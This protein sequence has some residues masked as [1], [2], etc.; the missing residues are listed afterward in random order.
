M[1]QANIK[2]WPQNYQK[3][4]GCV[5]IYYPI[6]YVVRSMP[7]NTQMY[8]NSTNYAQIYNQ[9]SGPGWNLGTGLAPAS[10]Q[11]RFLDNVLVCMRDN[12]CMREF[13]LFDAPVTLCWVAAKVLVQFSLYSACLYNKSSK[14]VPVTFKNKEKPKVKF[15]CLINSIHTALS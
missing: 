14:M 8:L 3:Y 2:S 5:Y 15:H 10:P 9:N 11:H 7:S 12:V 13:Y 4:V 6:L 1:K